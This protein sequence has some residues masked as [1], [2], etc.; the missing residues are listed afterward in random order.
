MFEKK[1]S[2]QVYITEGQKYTKTRVG[3]SGQ[4]GVNLPDIPMIKLEPVLSMPQAIM[5]DFI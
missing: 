3:F 1:R 5:N 2:L 4:V